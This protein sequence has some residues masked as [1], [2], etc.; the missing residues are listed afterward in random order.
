MSDDELKKLFFGFREG[1]AGENAVMATEKKKEKKKERRKEEKKKEKKENKETK[2][3]AYQDSEQRNSQ[4]REAAHLDGA[5]D[6]SE[7]LNRP[8]VE[9]QS[10][11]RP[12]VDASAQKTYDDYNDDD[13]L[14]NLRVSATYVFFYLQL[15]YLGDFQV[16]ITF[17]F[18]AQSLWLISWLETKYL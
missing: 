15:L 17:Y 13:I 2:K 16:S 8:E 10:H 14:A 18:L 3:D 11:P 5:C 6:S 7:I 12:S 9:G 4:D 1:R